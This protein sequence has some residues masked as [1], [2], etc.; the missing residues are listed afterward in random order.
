MYIDQ[1]IKV[2]TLCQLT[3][4]TL[5]IEIHHHINSVDGLVRLDPCKRENCHL[6]DGRQSIEFGQLWHIG[7]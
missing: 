3:W 2:D 5:S 6:S 4:N 1:D 7:L